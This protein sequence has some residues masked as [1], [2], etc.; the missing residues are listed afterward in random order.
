MSTGTRL[1]DKLTPYVAV[2]VENLG[3]LA[4]VFS[5]KLGLVLGIPPIPPRRIITLTWW[6]GLRVPMTS[7]ATSAGAFELLL[8]LPMP[9]RSKGRD[10]TK[11]DPLV[12]QVGG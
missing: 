7:R 2:S 11:N 5:L 4:F 10:Q 6:G 1:K 3:K 8:G 12:L 9:N